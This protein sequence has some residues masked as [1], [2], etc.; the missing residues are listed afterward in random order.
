[1]RAAS[2]MRSMRP[3]PRTVGLAQ[4]ATNTGAGPASTTSRAARVTAVYSS[5][6]VV[7]FTG[8][9]GFPI[10][11][12]RDAKAMA[13]WSVRGLPATF[14]VDRQGRLAFRA[15]GGRE[16]DDPEIVAA[17]RQLLGTKASVAG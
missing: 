10:L 2:V 12:D 3:L 11:F 4:A 9:A 6:R 8:V 7:T 5:S 15:T 16:F 13:A 14:L 17:I 1:M